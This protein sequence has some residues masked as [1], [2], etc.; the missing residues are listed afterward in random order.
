[1]LGATP[2]SDAQEP[3]KIPPGFLEGPPGQPGSVGRYQVVMDAANIILLDTQT[4]RMW[5]RSAGNSIG[6]WSEAGPQWTRPQ[7]RP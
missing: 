2:T 5:Q 7:R 4:G 3:L 6:D 1:M